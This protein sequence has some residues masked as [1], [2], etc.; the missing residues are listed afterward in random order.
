[1]GVTRGVREGCVWRAR[2]APDALSGSGRTRTCVA[3]AD[4]A[5]LGGALGPLSRAGFI[6]VLTATQE[7]EVRCAPNH[8]TELTIN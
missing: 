7:R 4:S 3:L 6:L 2:T 5:R 8:E 1:M